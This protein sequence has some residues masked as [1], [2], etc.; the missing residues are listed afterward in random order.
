MFH[1]VSG[2]LRV[3]IAGQPHPHLLFQ[4]ISATRG[5]ATPRSPPARPFITSRASASSRR[6]VPRLPDGIAGMMTGMTAAWRRRRSLPP[7]PVPEYVNYQSRV[8]KWCTIGSG[9][10]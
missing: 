7:A 10:R 3:T 8:R 1:I 6:P 4:L 9:I 2:E 5:G